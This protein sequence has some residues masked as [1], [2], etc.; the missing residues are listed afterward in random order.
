M[1]RR[2]TTLRCQQL[3]AVEK[4]NNPYTMMYPSTW[5]T[6]IDNRVYLLTQDM[7]VSLSVNSRHLETRVQDEQRA[8]TTPCSLAYK[9]DILPVQGS[10][11]KVLQWLIFKLNYENNFKW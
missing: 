8:R 5:R 4:L 6:H 3:E 1:C 9:H 10:R 7:N 2:A 11:A